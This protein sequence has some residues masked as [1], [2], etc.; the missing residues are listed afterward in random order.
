MSMAALPVWPAAVQQ[1]VPG[2]RH[3]VQGRGSCAV[4]GQPGGFALEPCRVAL[5]L[6]ACTS[7]CSVGE[8]Q[9]SV[10]SAF[11]A[12][13]PCRRRSL[14]RPPAA[15][16]VWCLRHQQVCL[17]VPALGCLCP[18]QGLQPLRQR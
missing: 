2:N 13:P 12:D 3:A 11:R 1:A 4:P 14:P 5:S 8:E 7:C 16:R 6:A 9:G 10:S 15:R 17:S 18:G